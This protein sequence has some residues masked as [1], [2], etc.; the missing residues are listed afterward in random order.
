MGLTPRL[1]LLGA[2]E[3]I[4]ETVIESLP[5]EVG[6]GRAGSA[7]LWQQVGTEV[8]RQSWGGRL[9]G[10]TCSHCC[11]LDGSVLPVCTH[12]HPQ[13]LRLRLPPPGNTV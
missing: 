7:W 3:V 1:S 5:G 11:R 8:S 9:R 13:G 4:P 6:K 12:P 2:R 10:P